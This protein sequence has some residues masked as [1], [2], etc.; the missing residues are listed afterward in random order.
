MAF[1]TQHLTAICFSSRVKRHSEVQVDEMLIDAMGKLR[2]R[3]DGE[4]MRE[5]R[6]MWILHMIGTNTGH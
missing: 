4:T 2:I 6:E 3:L 5:M 1:D